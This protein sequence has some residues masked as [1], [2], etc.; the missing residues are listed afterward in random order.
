M[1]VNHAL[2]TRNPVFFGFKRIRHWLESFAKLNNFFVALLLIL[3]IF[4]KLFYARKEIHT[5]DYKGD[6]RGMSK[7]F[8]FVRAQ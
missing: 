8:G 7:I 4:K 5:R 2:T 1:Q 6:S 3:K